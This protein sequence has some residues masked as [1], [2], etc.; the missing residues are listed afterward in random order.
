MV[1]VIV[2]RHAEGWK[3]DIGAAQLASLPALAFEGATK[4][5]RPPL[6]VRAFA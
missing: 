3:V 4:R 2:D 6:V 5:N 1:G